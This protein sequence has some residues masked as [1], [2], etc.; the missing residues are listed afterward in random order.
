MKMKGNRTMTKSF[1][2]TERY[3]MAKVKQKALS[4]AK[5]LTPLPTLRADLRRAVEDA[6]WLGEA[7]RM[8]EAHSH[9]SYVEEQIAKGYLYEPDW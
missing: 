9:L 6:E 1:K 5:G 3:V 7:S 4:G 2:Q 8:E